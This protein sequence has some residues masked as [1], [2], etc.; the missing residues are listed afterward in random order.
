M[1]KIFGA[2]ALLA[3]STPSFADEVYLD[4]S[5]G[6]NMGTILPWGGSDGGGFEGPKD[7]AKISVVW[8]SDNGFYAAYT[9]ISH[10]TAGP[11]F[12]AREE[13]Q[14]DMFEFGKKFVLWRR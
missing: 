11:P 9:H 7:I 6:Y 14:I 8:E 5:L 13:D 4:L 3:L 10:L 1:K 12:N 2:V